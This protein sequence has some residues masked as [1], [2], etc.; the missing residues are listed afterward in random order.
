MTSRRPIVLKSRKETYPLMCDQPSMNLRITGTLADPTPHCSP[1]K[2]ASKN[3]KDILHTTCRQEAVMRVVALAI[4]LL[5]RAG[6]TLQQRHTTLTDSCLQSSPYRR[7]KE[8]PTKHFLISLHGSYRSRLPA[9]A[10]KPSADTEKIPGA[11]VRIACS[12][13]RRQPAK[14]ISSEHH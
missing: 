3:S 12:R 8:S 6:F 13:A 9:A 2:Q 4:S 14:P 1:T 7:I 10:H 11:E 5:Q